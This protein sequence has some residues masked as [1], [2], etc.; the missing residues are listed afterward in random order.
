VADIGGAL[1]SAVADDVRDKPTLR[2]LARIYRV[3]AGARIRADFQYRVS[4]FGYTLTQG[5]ITL[6]DFLQIAVIFGNVRQLDGWNVA[7][8]AFLYGTSAVAF[9]LGD[10]FISQVERAPQR[11]RMGT[12]DSLLI[13]PLGAMFQLCAD[14]FAFRRLGKLVQGIAV[15][16]Y[17]FSIL[18]VSWSAGKVAAFVLML[19][20]GT[21]IFA[22]IWVISSSIA[23]WVVE[24]GEMMNAFTY[25]SSFATEYPLHIMAKW[26]RRVFTFIVPAAFVNYYPS[27]YILDKRD[28]FHAPGWVRFASPVVAIILLL[29]ANATWKT[30][31]RHYRST[32]S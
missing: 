29:V 8:V 26:L 18:D 31:I 16:V 20:S 13:R 17:A 30:A 10:V 9:H 4:F 24:G 25:G 3:M 15:L 27:L 1:N 22:A 32:G 28:P 12:F 21:A 14:D 23:F 5:L 19:A 11:I 6:L 2:E 7:D